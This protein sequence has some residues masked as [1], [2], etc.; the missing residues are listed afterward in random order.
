MARA[1]FSRKPTISGIKITGTLT[2]KGG[3]PVTDAEAEQVL[4]A[5]IQAIDGTYFETETLAAVVK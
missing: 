3:G 5:V 4:A 1:E 2:R